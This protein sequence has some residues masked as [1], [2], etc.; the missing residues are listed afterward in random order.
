M[1]KTIPKVKTATSFARLAPD[2]ALVA[3]G[4]PAAPA[5][6]EIPPAPA[7][8]VVTADGAASKAPGARPDAHVDVHVDVFTAPQMPDAAHPPTDGEKSAPAPAPAAVEAEKMK[9]WEDKRGLTETN[10]LYKMPVE[11]VAKMNWVMDNVP[12]MNKQRIVRDAVNAE[13]DRLIAEHYKP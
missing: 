11:V 7:T 10:L 2:M 4:T 3:T 12:R 13:L 8:V 1:T 5:A 9:P 6:A